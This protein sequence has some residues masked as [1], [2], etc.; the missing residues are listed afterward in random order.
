MK[1]FV[2]ITVGIYAAG[3]TTWWILMLTAGDGIWWLALV[4]SFAAFL[5]SPLLVFVPL[6]ILLKSK[7]V[8][9][10]AAAPLL[11]FVLIYG[12]LFVPKISNSPNSEEKSLTIM[13]FN[14][15]GSVPA[16]ET[17][18]AILNNGVIPDIVLLQ[19]NT[20]KMT[21]LILKSTQ[22]HY[23]HVALAPT[24]NSKGMGVLSRFPLREIDVD[25]L[26][27]PNWSIQAVEADVQGETLTLFNVHPKATSAYTFARDKMRVSKEVNLSFKGRYDLFRKLMIDI[28]ARMTPV[29][30]G[31]DFNCTELSDV[32][33]MLNKTLDDA[34][35]T[36]GWSFGHTFPA[37]NYYL[38]G[39][40]I[41]TKLVRIDKIF[42][43]E[44]ISGDWC[45]VG[46]EAGKSNHY[47]VL[48]RLIL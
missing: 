14:V 40:P 19:E 47:P 22:H 4:N 23:T 28:E 16:E 38:A 15:F 48:A 30:V 44:R 8:G 7:P 5:F 42:Y 33:R 2:T 45:R 18:K 35:Q 1:R 31:G 11:I 43:S 21:S 20:R 3:I 10:I 26:L 24:N 41:P 37:S 32:H 36:S 34:H 39:M 29:I 27:A 25:H 9:F 13:T 46:K 12:K 6:C 17:A